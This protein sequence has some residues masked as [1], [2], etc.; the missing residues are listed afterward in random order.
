MRT[1][2][3]PINGDAVARALQHLRRHVRWRA[4]EGRR[5]AGQLRD[6]LLGQTKVGEACASGGAVRARES[7][8][9]I[10]HVRATLAMT[11]RRAKAA[12]SRQAFPTRMVWVT[13]RY[14]P[15][16]D[17]TRAGSLHDR[18]GRRC[19]ARAAPVHDARAS[20]ASSSGAPRTDGASAGGP[21]PRRAACR[22]WSLPSHNSGCALISSRCACSGPRLQC[23]KD[24]GGVQL[25]ARLGQLA[26]APQVEEELASRQ[27]GHDKE[28]LHGALGERVAQLVPLDDVRLVQHLHRVQPTARPLLDQQHLRRTPATH[29]Q[30]PPKRELLPASARIARAARHLPVCPTAEDGHDFEI[31]R[32]QLL[33]L[34]SGANGCALGQRLC[35]VGEAVI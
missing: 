32:A 26:L 9:T 2:A 18:H 7:A 34:R 30:Q 23:E 15:R 25:R 4:T 28:E 21:E 35:G 5:A 11:Q 8:V 13:R 1:E 6:R 16:G 14:D 17:T 29:T 20:R 10:A 19:R 31:A 27:V 3:P 24:L 22:G 12:W 33:L